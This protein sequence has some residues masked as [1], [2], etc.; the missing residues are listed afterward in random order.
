[1]YRLI[2][3]DSSTGT[4]Y[5]FDKDTIVRG[6]ISLVSA[7]DVVGSEL[8][9]DQ[10]SADVYYYSG[11][12][13]L[14]ALRS[15][16]PGEYEVV[17]TADRYLF[18]TADALTPDLSLIPYGSDAVL[19]R[20][21][22]V[23]MKLHVVK[24]VQ[25]GPGKYSIE[26]ASGIELLDGVTHL[27][28][29]YT[30]ATAGDLI[31][32]IIG[33][34]F[35]YTIDQDVAAELVTG[36]LPIDT[37]RSNLHRLLYALGISILRTAQGTVRFCYLQ[38]GTPAAIPPGRTFIGGNI[39]FPRP[40]VAVEVTEHAWLQ[41]Q[42]AD[43][44]EIFSN[45]G[46]TPEDHLLVQLDEPHYDYTAS[47][48]TIN[49]SGDNYV[50]VSGVGTVS[51]RPY[52]HITQ[53]YRL[54]GAADS[55]QVVTETDDTLINSLNSPNV[56]QR[57]LAYYTSRKTVTLPIKV[58]AEAAGDLVSFRDPFGGTG[59]GFISEM[60]GIATSF[61]KASCRIVTDYSP[62]GQGN[63]YKNRVLI[64]AAQEWQLP[65]GVTHL[66]V[67][68]IGGGAGGDGGENGEN[69]YGGTSSGR[70][71]TEITSLGS[72]HVHGWIYADGQ[73]GVAAGGAG[74]AAGTQGKVLSME[75]DNSDESLTAIDAAPGVGGS[76]GTVGGSGAAGTPSTVRLLVG[77]SYGETISSEDGDLLAGFSDPFSG[78]VYAAEG[79]PGTDGGDGGQTDT[80]S[81]FA[82]AGE[83]GLPGGDA[84]QYQGGAGG[85]GV[86]DTQYAY[87]ASGGGGGGAAKGADGSPGG[88]GS[89]QLTPFSLVGGTGGNGANASAPPAASYGGGG[90][91]GNGGG[92]GGN[93]AG[94][95]V[96]PYA[97]GV[98][99]GAGGTGG[100]GTPGADGGDGIV[101]IYY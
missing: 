94:C 38:A 57:L 59:N 49:D 82:Y 27:G 76:G 41:D 84:G 47:G 87:T 70:G 12:P 33:T 24:I 11:Y 58:E 62:T 10:M 4:V 81:L 69:G 39:E 8:A 31:A 88:D 80:E 48:L 22:D 98:T 51:A 45:A 9:A 73:Q 29:L 91:G 67:V 54:D 15:T 90:S 25:I 46:R 61:L 28:G 83:A 20:G 74:G 14:F 55:D 37:A 36:W 96:D 97:S 75:I 100:A 65:A 60:S 95:L 3:T 21:E 30:R 44:E 63:Y 78:D 50:I 85:L 56:A 86:K 5:A 89:V 72:A 79:V 93:G 32:E 77:G 17:E 101:I 92:G 16:V 2:I 52:R 35:D 71:L 43:P 7:V 6:S 13:L 18:G 23:A 53:V 19:Y 66:R 1:M 34:A 99:P 26:C 42:G 64:T 40:V 68:I